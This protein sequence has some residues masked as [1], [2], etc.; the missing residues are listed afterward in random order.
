MFFCFEPY[1]CQND[2]LEAM[3]L[4]WRDVSSKFFGSVQTN[5]ILKP[6]IYENDVG[7]WDLGVAMAAA[8]CIHPSHREFGVT[9]GKPRIASVST[10]RAQL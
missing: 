10:F 3:K 2:I 1:G 5:G 8:T 4:D 7:S 6:G 9:T